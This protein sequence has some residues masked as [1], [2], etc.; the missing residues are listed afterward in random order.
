MDKLVS[1]PFSRITW[2][3]INLNSSD[4]VKDYF[5]KH[6][7]IP[8][9]YN[10]KKDSLLKNTLKETHPEIVRPMEQRLKA[11]IQ[12][13]QQCLIKNKMHE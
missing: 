4:Q 13:Y 9:E 8:I 1:G 6:G 12:T 10:Y 3:P 5:L 11:I 2:E 7:W